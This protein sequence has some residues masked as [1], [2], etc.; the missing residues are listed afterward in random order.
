MEHMTDQQ[1][2]AFLGGRRYGI[3]TT[4][5]ADG[6]PVPIP[7]WFEWDGE[8]ARLF[9]KAHAPKLRRIAA[10]A[11]VALLASNNPDE[12]E[13]WVLIKGCA[14][15]VTADGIALARRLAARYW[16]LSDAKHAQTLRDWESEEWAVIEI[17]P[18]SIMSP[19]NA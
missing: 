19:A 14:S 5:G 11:R 10:D 4:N 8:C 3:L 2:D 1:R 18:E 16:D 12:P 6:F 17:A 15:V 7:V 13:Q 9:S